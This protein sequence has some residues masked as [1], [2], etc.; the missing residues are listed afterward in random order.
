[1]NDLMYP[2][3]ALSDISKLEIYSKQSPT[4]WFHM[5][6]C[7]AGL[8]ERLQTSFQWLTPWQMLSL[9]TSQSIFSPYRCNWRYHKSIS[10]PNLQ[11]AAVLWRPSYW[12]ESGALNVF[13]KCCQFASSDGQWL[14]WLLP[15]PCHRHAVLWAWRPLLSSGHTASS[16]CTMMS[17]TDAI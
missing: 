10:T 7:R 4:T 5:P 17:L 2:V 12:Q 15:N 11:P 8:P 6:V 14:N 16:V 9:S 13:L 1:M 3:K